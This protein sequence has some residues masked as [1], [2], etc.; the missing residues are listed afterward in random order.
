MNQQHGLSN[1]NPVMAMQQ[2]SP[3]PQQANQ[4]S[5]AGQLANAP[6]PNVAVGV[7]GVQQPT[8]QPSQQQQSQ[9][10]QQQ[11]AERIDNISKV[12]SLAIPLRES[13]ANTLKVAAQCLQHN[14]ASDNGTT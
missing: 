13:L 4:P 11:Q 1:V 7:A 12:K 5:V 8:G 10:S 3:Q 6:G 14:S 2:P 9:M